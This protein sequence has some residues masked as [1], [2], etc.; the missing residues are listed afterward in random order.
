MDANTKIYLGRDRCG[1]HGSPR[2]CP[3]TV[4][5]RIR[6]HGRHQAHSSAA[7][8]RADRSTGYEGEV[9]IPTDVNSH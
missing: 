1:F 8:C 4:Q 2:P 3:S 7:G 9:S 6:W 5:A